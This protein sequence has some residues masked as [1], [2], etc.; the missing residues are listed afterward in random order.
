M[1]RRM[2]VVFAHPDD[3]SFGMASTIARYVAQG[4]E[5]SLICATNGD[6]GTVAE[7]HMT[8]FSS[9]GEL[10]LA[11]LECASAILGFHE[12]VTLGYRDSGMMGTPENEHPR[13]LWQAP[14]DEVTACVADVMRR[15]RPQVVITFD[16]YGGYGHPDHIKIHQATVAAFHSLQSDGARPQKL[17]YL[18]FP[19]RLMK[20]GLLMVRLFGR[21]PS[22]MGTNKDLDFKNILDR[23]LP[24][25]ARIPVREYYDIGVR[26]AECHA[27]QLS[28][29]P[30]GSFP[31][32]RFFLRQ[33]QASEGYTRAHPAPRP[34]EP[35][36]RD[37]FLGTVVD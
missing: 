19:R 28:G 26:A 20:F 18:S 11:E 29:S 10:R 6:V 12:V 21:D 8:G 4:V 13:S 24:T 36:E 37:L 35:M 14:L 33:L 3:E 16:P 30:Q 34:G 23:L 2:L 15:L 27:S 9:V 7:Q 1:P 22:K 5:V 32:A 25:H 17:Y 31:L